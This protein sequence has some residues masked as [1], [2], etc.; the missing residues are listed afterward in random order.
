LEKAKSHKVRISLEGGS[1][2]GGY[3]SSS[4]K[5]QKNKNKNFVHKKRKEKGT[6]R[7]RGGGGE[8]WTV[9]GER[10]LLE[11]RFVLGGV[12]SGRAGKG[13]LGKGKKGIFFVEG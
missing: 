2:R 5:R 11:K 4:M 6:S 13:G 3:P 1:R 8:T 10:G 7:N 12:G 9:K